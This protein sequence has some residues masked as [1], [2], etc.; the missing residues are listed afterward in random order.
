MPLLPPERLKALTVAAAAGG[1]GG[2]APRGAVSSNPAAP[3]GEPTVWRVAH[4]L[5]TEIGPRLFE[6]RG[7]L[8]VVRSCRFKVKSAG[9][10]GSGSSPQR[11]SGDR[12]PRGFHLSLHPGGLSLWGLGLFEVR[13]DGFDN[14]WDNS[15]LFSLVHA[16]QINPN[17]VGEVLPHDKEM[18]PFCYTQCFPAPRPHRGIWLTLC[19]L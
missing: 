7:R 8:G 5:Q 16:D 17:R 15:L 10:T 1:L 14:R 6:L 11:L 3:R 12:R 13:E 9:M 19:S 18:L 2:L 4:P